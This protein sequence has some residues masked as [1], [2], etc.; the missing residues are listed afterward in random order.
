MPA[1]QEYKL[2]K[3]RDHVYL[4]TFEKQYDLNMHFLRAQEYYESANDEFRGKPFSLWEYIRWYAVDRDGS[5]GT[6]TYTTDWSGF[7]IPSTVL[8]K[9]YFGD[10]LAKINEPLTPYDKTM[11]DICT[12]LRSMEG[13]AKYYLAGATEKGSALDHEMAHALW[14]VEPEYR[15]EQEA[16]LAHM[17]KKYG[18]DARKLI[19]D[20][21]IK[22]GYCDDVVDDESQAY[23]STGLGGLLESNLST[24]GLEGR[25]LT[26]ARKPFI[27]TYEKW[28]VT[29]DMPW[30]TVKKKKRKKN[31]DEIAA[32]Q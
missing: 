30:R 11:I 1:T 23:L 16:N 27:A 10:V 22:E 24:I 18:K 21:L 9:L 29:A 13:D 32:N 7:N 31:T 6:F 19:R 25:K 15:R 26:W 12:Q 17:D 14:F 20:A 2:R 4:L 8:E 3:L 5:K 28:V